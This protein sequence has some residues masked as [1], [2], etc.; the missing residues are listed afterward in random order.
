MS[1]VIILVFAVAT[2]CTNTAS[3][4]RFSLLDVDGDV[5][6]L[7]IQGEEIEPRIVKVVTVAVVIVVMFVD[8][9]MVMCTY[10]YLD[11]PEPFMIMPDH[12]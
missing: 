9:G 6:L 7:N 4:I 12:T 8:V 10:V 2:V 1:S 3:G 11:M 5:W